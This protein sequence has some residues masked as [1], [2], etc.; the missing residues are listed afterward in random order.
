[1]REDE[2]EEPTLLNTVISLGT[3]ERVDGWTYHRFKLLSGSGL[4]LV[5]VGLG[6]L[7]LPLAVGTGN[8]DDVAFPAPAL[9]SGFDT[10]GRFCRR[11]GNCVWFAEGVGRSPTYESWNISF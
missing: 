7:P 1:M 10:L 9:G 6:A 4:V 2:D 8:G 5:S 11:T 3:R